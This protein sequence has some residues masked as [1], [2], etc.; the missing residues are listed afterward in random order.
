ME[1]Q[2]AIV[3]GVVGVLAGVRAVL[4]RAGA[5]ILENSMQGLHAIGDD[6]RKEASDDRVR[7]HP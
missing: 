2:I 5:R 1:W 6:E 4:L 7:V 3:V